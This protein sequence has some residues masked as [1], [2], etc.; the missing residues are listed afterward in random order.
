MAVIYF[1]QIKK[2]PYNREFS[3]FWR[4]WRDLNSRVGVTD[5]LVFEARPFSHLGTSPYFIFG[6]LPI[7]KLAERRGFEPRKRLLPLT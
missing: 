1:F 5:L 2:L 7:K 4:R 6:L 3:F